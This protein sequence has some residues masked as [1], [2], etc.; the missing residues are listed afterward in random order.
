MNERIDV[1]QPVPKASP[2]LVQLQDVQKTVK[3]M[4]SRIRSDSSNQCPKILQNLAVLKPRSNTVF[5]HTQVRSMP[6]AKRS[7]H[8]QGVLVDS[9]DPGVPALLRCN[10][11]CQLVHKLN[12]RLLFSNPGIAKI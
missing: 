9:L 3:S 2:P 7:R 12:R 4:K 6:L 11:T 8:G 1:L 5:G 10:L